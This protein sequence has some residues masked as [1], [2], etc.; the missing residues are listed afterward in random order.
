[1]SNEVVTLLG[2]SLVMGFVIALFMEPNNPDDALYIPT[3]MHVCPE[4]KAPCN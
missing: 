4:W 1:M 2:I 3:R